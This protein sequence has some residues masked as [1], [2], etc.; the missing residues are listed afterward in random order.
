MLDERNERALP[1]SDRV[2]DAPL[3]LV[4]ENVP[5]RQLT[6][7]PDS[8]ELHA[9]LARGAEADQG[10]DGGSEGKGFVGREVTLLDRLDH[11]VLR[12]AD[13]KQVDEADDLA[14]A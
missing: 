1:G 4:V 9:L 10:T 7:T 8:A 13:G 2:G 11:T 3:V 5:V 12:L 14:L 6:E